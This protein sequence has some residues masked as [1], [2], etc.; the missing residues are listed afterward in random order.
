MVITKHN[1]RLK[2]TLVLLTIVLTISIVI[3]VLQFN[4]CH[5]FHDFV[6]NVFYA[7]LVSDL[8]NLN[9][10]VTTQITTTEIEAHKKIGGIV[11]GSKA[12]S[13]F[14]HFMVS[15][16]TLKVHNNRKR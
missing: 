10:T 2:L 14:W 13:Q 3:I 4:Y 12:D 16:S 8:D 7:R 15:G 6:D 5:D 1:C 9:E 11:G